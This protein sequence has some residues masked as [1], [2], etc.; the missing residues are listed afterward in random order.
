VEKVARRITKELKVEADLKRDKD[1]M[2]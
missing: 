2:V 1:R